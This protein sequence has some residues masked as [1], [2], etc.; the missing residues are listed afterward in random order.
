MDVMKV[1]AVDLVEAREDFVLGAFDAEPQILERLCSD[2]EL[3]RALAI[4]GGGGC[5]RLSAACGSK[6]QADKD[7]NDQGPYAAR[8]HGDSLGPSGA[9]EYRTTIAR[10][11]SRVNSAVRT[12]LRESS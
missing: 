5:I 3:L 8:F 7:G 4:G 11:G 6:H 9:A 2:D 12:N 10:R 1:V